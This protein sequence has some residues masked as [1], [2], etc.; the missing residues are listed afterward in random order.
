MKTFNLSGELRLGSRWNKFSKEIPAN[1]EDHARDLLF[2]RFGSKH[3]LPRRFINLLE[4]SEVEAS[5]V[6]QE[7]KNNAKARKETE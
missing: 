3:K 1:D 6:L 4:I 7:P 2:A 5:T